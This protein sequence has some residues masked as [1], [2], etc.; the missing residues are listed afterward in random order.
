MTI[1]TISKSDMITELPSPK[2]KIL[3]KQ[4]RKLS[5]RMLFDSNDFSKTS[6]I[7]IRDF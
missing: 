7:T 3:K 5:M 6:V 1:R 2:I 4:R